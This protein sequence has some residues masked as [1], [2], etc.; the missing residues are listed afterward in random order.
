M[1]PSVTD[2]HPPDTPLIAMCE[3]GQKSKHRLALSISLDILIS[4]KSIVGYR[5]TNKLLTKNNFGVEL[6]ALMKHIFV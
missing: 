5:L 6:N 1:E 3:A 2:E 4:D